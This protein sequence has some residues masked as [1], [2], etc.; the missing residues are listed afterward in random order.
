MELT[1]QLPFIAKSKSEF[2]ALKGMINMDET[3]DI[4]SPVELKKLIEKDGEEKK[5]KIC[6]YAR[7][8]LKNNRIAEILKGKRYELIEH[9]KTVVLTIEIPTAE[10]EKQNLCLND[11]EKPMKT[12][13]DKHD[14][15]V[16]IEKQE[17]SL[18]ISISV[19]QKYFEAN[20]DEETK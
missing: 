16:Q 9:R 2:T 14:Y 15:D 6:E 5:T 3:Y 17:S 4:P 11:L 20:E 18:K 13:L 19:P 1:N 12:L 10:L 7:Q 8:I